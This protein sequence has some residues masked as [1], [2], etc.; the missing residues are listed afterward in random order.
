MLVA[1]H[2]TRWTW[3]IDDSAINRKRVSDILESH[4]G[5]EVVET[6]RDFGLDYKEYPDIVAALASHQRRLRQL[7][8]PEE[9][10][11]RTAPAG[12]PARIL[13]QAGY[14][15]GEPRMEPRL[16]LFRR[17]CLLAGIASR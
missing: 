11:G 7:G 8:R 6:A 9:V 2:A 3:L 16:C 12:M 17:F 14:H 4:S 1:H 13:S 15:D 5:I 10:L